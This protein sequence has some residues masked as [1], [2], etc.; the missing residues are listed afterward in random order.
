MDDPAS[1]QDSLALLRSL[2]TANIH[3]STQRD[4]NHLT[5]T[6]AL[7]RRSTTTEQTAE[8]QQEKK[9]T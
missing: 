8:A 7:E 6:Q 2:Q 5:W 3:L 9:Q 4:V 1:E